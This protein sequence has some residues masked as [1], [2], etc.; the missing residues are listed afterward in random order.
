MGV[1]VDERAAALTS[2]GIDFVDPA[3]RGVRTCGARP[4]ETELRA[5]VASADPFVTEAAR[6]LVEA[7][8]KRF[9]PLLVALG[10][11]F[12]DPYGAAGRARPPW[13]WS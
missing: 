11:Q 7:G 5:G 1:V 9:R 13:S 8:G 3:R 4:V 12:G 2:I 6:H 10:A